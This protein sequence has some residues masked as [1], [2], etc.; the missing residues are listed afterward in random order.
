MK[1]F[2]LYS[3]TTVIALLVFFI[4]KIFDLKDVIDFIGIGAF[5]ILLPFTLFL[6]VINL[7]I[8]GTMAGFSN[9]YNKFKKA[10][11]FCL[12][13]TYDTILTFSLFEVF[14]GF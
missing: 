14:F 10:S 11:A 5:F 12:W 6:W 2:W 4:I 7:A 1:H 13:V 9:N 3:L 8:F